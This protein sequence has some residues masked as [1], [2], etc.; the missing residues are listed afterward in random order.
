[1]QSLSN[2][3]GFTFKVDPESDCF[4]P[5]PLP[6]MSGPSRYTCPSRFLQQPLLWSLSC[7]LPPVREIFLKPKSDP[8]TLLLRTVMAPISLRRK[9]K[10]LTKYGPQALVIS[11]QTPSLTC[12]PSP[13]SCCASRSG[14]W[15]SLKLTRPRVYLRAFALTVFLPRTLFL[16]EM[17]SLL[18]YFL[19]VS[20]QVSSSHI[21]LA[22]PYLGLV[23][24]FSFALTII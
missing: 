10:V 9:A 19:Q 5:L 22:P 7:L 21:P 8:I 2:P 17:K 18:L 1:M 11:L 6:P 15:L 3:V 20:A 12:L 23:P 24:F 4:S 13:H 16:Q 14:L